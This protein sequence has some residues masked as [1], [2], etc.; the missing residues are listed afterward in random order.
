MELLK[1]AASSPVD[2]GYE[3]V[4]FESQSRPAAIKP[5]EM[6][7]QGVLMHVR[8]GRWLVAGLSTRPAVPGWPPDLGY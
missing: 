5:P 7:S 1:T 2:A 3:L 4:L 8:D 6:S